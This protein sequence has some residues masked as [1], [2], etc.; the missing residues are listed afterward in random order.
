[1]LRFQ[2]PPAQT[3]RDFL[4]ALRDSFNGALRDEAWARGL[5]ATDAS[6]YQQTPAA[7]LAPQSVKD[8]QKAL[9]L[10]SDHH[11]PIL[12]RG[13][14]TSLAGQCTIDGGLVIDVSQHFTKIG[15][16]N[17]AEGWVIVEPGVVRDTLNAHLAPKGVMFAPE[18]STSNRAN[19]GGMIGNNSSG[20]MSIR[21][22]KTIDHVLGAWAV[23]ADGREIYFGRREEM[24]ADGCALLDALLEI[25]NRNRALIEERFPKTMRRAGGYMLDE[26]LGDDP[27]LAKILC[28]SEGTLAFLTR[29]KLKLEPKLK[30]V[31][32]VA[33]HFKSVVNSLRAMPD[34]A[35]HNPLSAELMDEE[36]LT[37]CADNET[38]K[39]MMWW[40]HGH[41]EAVIAVE[42]DGDTQ[43]AA[44]ARIRDLVADLKAK[45]WGYEY[46]ELMKP[47]ERYQIIEVR[48][49]GLGIMLKMIGDPK[50]I[51]FIEDAA[52]PLE[53]LAEYVERVFA[54]AAKEKVRVISYGHASVGVLHLRPI[55]NLKT[56]E[57]RDTLARISGKVMPLV[58]EYGG[59]WASEH[60]D[61]IARGAQ[62]HDFWGEDMI[63]VFRE[64]KAL[65]DPKGLFNPGKIFDT[66]PV[67]GPLRYTAEYKQSDYKSAY[68]FAAEGGFQGAVEMCNGVGACRK[69]GSGT[70]CPS[71]MATR[72][73]KDSTRGRANALR[74]A[75]SGQLGEDAMTGDG[76]KEVLDLCLEC[77]ACKTE[78]PSNVDMAKMKSEFLHAFNTRHGAT[79]RDKALGFSPHTARLNSGWRAR[80]VNPILRNPLTRRAFAKMLGVAVER[81]LP[82][83]AT[84]T[85]QT[86]FDKRPKPKLPK[87]AP[88]V[89]LFDDTYASCHETEI[90]QWAVRVLE[91]LGFRVFLARAG[92][93]QRPLMSKGFL[94]EA[95]A[96]GGKTI[97]NLDKYAK[98]GMK[99]LTLEPSCG[100][101]LKDDLKDLVEDKGAAK[102]VSAATFPIEQFIEEEAVAGRIKIELPKAAKDGYLLHG[103][104]HQKALFGTGPL[105]RIM[106]GAGAAMEEVDSGCCGMAGSFGYE[107][108]HYEISQQIG[109][110]RLFPAVRAAAKK[111][112]V[113]NG[114]SCRHQVADATGRRP[115]HFIEALGRAM[116]LKES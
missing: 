107:E 70:M 40:M 81:P 21:Y 41:P 22:G 73:E 35:A 65:F 49:H 31:A 98:A 29:A 110:S 61:G 77:K 53:T 78:C 72:E 104:C 12:P 101:A 79:L 44:E 7:V 56:R 91:H 28:A 25:V 39:A 103:H 89:I 13:A 8:I 96:G 93:C 11:M 99:I 58:R 46:A 9:A 113:A 97:A 20:M 62:N 48:K 17:E 55:L 108:E 90:G 69:V 43:E 18:T 42:M 5:Y 3:Q 47:E 115:V 116:G 51:A 66:P 105:K 74:L 32:A 71:Y 30:H 23:L 45:G 94:D 59:S 68:A 4:K 10:C 38:T 111:E 37:M 34:I 50:P 64:V 112:L 82:P 63:A 60:G 102:R 84:E 27:N 86:W 15:Q 87:D 26:F 75:M 85:L 88:E 6:M 19:V 57:G 83:Y 16:V 95:K 109:E 14:G 100:S 24:D 36:L 52:I 67:S 106:A 76:L 33:V 1:M 92:C 80:F 54:I 114:F 2:D